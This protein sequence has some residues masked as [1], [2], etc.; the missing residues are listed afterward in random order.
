[1]DNNV[2]WLH[3]SRC[4]IAVEALRRNRFDAYYVR[5]KDQAREKTLAMIPEGASV[6]FGGS[7][8][9]F[10]AGIVEALRDPRW[11]LT[12][13]YAPG[14]SPE[15]LREIFLQALRV[16]YFLTSANAVSL[17]GQIFLVDGANT[18][19]A[20][21]LFG[22]AHVILVIGANKVCSDAAA[23][24]RYMRDVASPANCKRLSTKTPCTAT[25]TC[26]NCDSP[27]RICNSTVVLH[28]HNI[29]SEHHQIHVIM[30][31]EEMGY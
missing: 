28:K 10:E 29:R 1:M 25:G 27:E 6:A 11:K 17:D 26:H 2:K 12:D 20:P 14:L 19:V 3:E 21:V 8:T 15:Q 9:L 16:D 23:A 22:P 18:R 24:Q 13:R 7:M 5:D 4:K 30:A 31:G